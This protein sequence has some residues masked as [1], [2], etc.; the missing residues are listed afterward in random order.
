MVNAE[1]RRFTHHKKA[2]NGKKIKNGSQQ[3]SNPRPPAP[4]ADAQMIQ[5]P[6]RLKKK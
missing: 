6:S 3:D 1:V 4:L 2:K 5:L